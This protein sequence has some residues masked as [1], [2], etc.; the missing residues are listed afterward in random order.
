[1]FRKIMVFCITLALVSGWAQ[2]AFAQV[3][4]GK[5]APDFTLADSNGN[6]VSLAQ[7]KGKYVVL[8]WL[9]YDCPFVRKHYSSGNMQNLQRAYTQKGV[10]WLAVL[11][12]PAGQAGKLYGAQTTPHMFVI[13]PRG[14]LIYQGAIDDIRSPNPDDVAKAKNY[15]GAALDEAM[16]G[17]PVS[18]PATKSYGCS[19]KYQQ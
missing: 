6:Q 19:V 10:I 13:D 2:G 18:V 17:K 11:L 8:E 15:V 4:N 12:D 5:A 1:M 16:S 7:F 14:I 9:N 3:E